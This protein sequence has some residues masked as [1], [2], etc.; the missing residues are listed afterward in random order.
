MTLG[1]LG[2]NLCLVARNKQKGVDVK[3]EIL[4][5]GAKVDIRIVIADFKESLHMS[6]WDNLELEIKKKTIEIGILVNNV[7][8]ANE[9]Q[10]FQEISPGFT[11][12]MGVINT[13]PVVMLT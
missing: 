11:H 7:G 6:F 5:A 2:F 9:M 12:E 10:T 8:V 1:K 3:E 13:T 4:K